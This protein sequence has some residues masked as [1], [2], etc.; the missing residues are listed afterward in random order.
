MPD[1]KSHRFKAL[2]ILGSCVQILLGIICI[3]TLTRLY[4]FIFDAY[5]LSPSHPDQNLV[6]LEKSAGMLGSLF[7]LITGPTFILWQR[8]AFRNLRALNVEGVRSKEWYCIWG[9]LI[10]L[11]CFYIPMSVTNEIWKASSP[12]NLDA[13]SWKS[14]GS[15]K[16]V[17][18]WWIAWLGYSIPNL[19]RV[20]VESS[21]YNASNPLNFFASAPFFV[22]LQITYCIG[23]IL[24]IIVVRDVSVR[25]M[26]KHEALAL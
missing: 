26:R 15:S 3:L 4:G 18:A 2:N 7:Y 6:G 21:P 23:A 1:N 13:T 14:A 5:L 24:A 17:I 9:F 8:R 22:I 19:I 16:V 25:Q 20:V 11:A 12:R 10:P